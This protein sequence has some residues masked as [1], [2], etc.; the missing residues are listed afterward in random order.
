MRAWCR[1]FMSKPSRGKE[2]WSFA[3]PKLRN[4]PTQW[5]RRGVSHGYA[6]RGGDASPSNMPAA[7]RER[8]KPLERNERVYEENT[9]TINRLWRTGQTHLEN[10]TVW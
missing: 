8:M 5:A 4:Q 7:E 2:A 1:V 6:G 3:R 10:V 9:D